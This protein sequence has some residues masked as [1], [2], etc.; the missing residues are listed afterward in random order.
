[1]RVIITGNIFIPSHSFTL[2][3]TVSDLL[4]Q[5]PDKFLVPFQEDLAFL[6]PG[7]LIHPPDQ[8]YVLGGR[9]AI[10]LGPQRTD[11]VVLFLV[12]KAV[13]QVNYLM[14]KLMSYNNIPHHITGYTQFNTNILLDTVN[15]LKDILTQLILVRYQISSHIFSHFS[16]F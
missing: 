4:L 3:L 8:G 14:V 2:Q 1:M 9:V 5:V 6:G 16:T 13:H 11:L 7:A 10:V 15:I 12:F